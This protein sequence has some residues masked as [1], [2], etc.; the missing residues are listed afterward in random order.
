MGTNFANKKCASLFTSKEASVVTRLVPNSGRLS[1]MSTVLTL[2]V[3]TTVTPTSSW[4]ASTCTTTR[5]LVV[6]TCLAPSS[7]TS[8][9]V[10]WTPSVPA[11][12]VSSSVL[13]T[14]SSARPVPVTIGPR[15]TTPRVLS[16]STPSST[17]SARRLSPVTASR[18]S[19]SATPSVVVPVPVWEHSS[20]PRSVRSTQ[21]VWCS[22]S[23][24]CHP[25]RCPTPLSSHTTPPSPFTSSLRTPMSAC[26]SI[27]RP[28]TISA[29]VPSSS[30]PQPTETSTTSVPPVCLASPV[31]FVSLVSSTLTF[32]SSESISS[33][34]HVFTSSSLGSPH[35]PP[36]G[37]SSTALLPSQSSPSRCSTPRT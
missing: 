4:S 16:S 24:S 23:P 35:S 2:P 36:V 30:P 34:S 26:V 8:S 9:Q 12:S 19:S 37:P 31:V 22:P 18:V 14:S 7:W 15:V 27:T 25:L 3:P 29:P 10:P 32:A 17:S 11:H 13:I 33:H 28:S 6:A 21:T 1:P 5:P 20:S